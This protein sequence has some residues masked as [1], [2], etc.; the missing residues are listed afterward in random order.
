MDCQSSIDYYIY[1]WGGM[2]NE[3]MKDNVE[4]YIQKDLVKSRY[5]HTHTHTHTLIFIIIY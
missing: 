5:G 1:I 2:E 4:T 3:I